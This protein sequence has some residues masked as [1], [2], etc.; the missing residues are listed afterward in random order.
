[1]FDFQLLI[2]GFSLIS[3]MFE[4]NWFFIYL[5]ARHVLTEQT[6]IGLFSYAQLRPK[7]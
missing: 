7:F 3:F 5:F 6:I 1:M 4:K 2:T